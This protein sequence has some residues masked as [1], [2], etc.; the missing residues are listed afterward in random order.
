M[1][2]YLYIEECVSE[3]LWVTVRVCEWMALLCR[4]KP[5]R[6]QQYMKDIFF[7]NG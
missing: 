1:I 6:S 3:M 5:G 7:L 4:I 2:R